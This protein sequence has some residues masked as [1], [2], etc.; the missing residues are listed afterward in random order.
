MRRVL[1]TLFIAGMLN[2][3]I[4][5]AADI[6]LL[7]TSDQRELDRETLRI[8]A[9]ADLQDGVRKLEAMF[10]ADPMAINAEAGKAIGQDSAAIAYMALQW[11]VDSDPDR[12]KLMW[13]GD[14]PHRWFGMDIPWASY[15]FQNQDDIYRQVAIDPHA[16]YEISGRRAGNPPVQARFGLFK[17][18]IDE[19]PVG[20]Q[21]EDIVAE[22]DGSFTITIDSDPANGRANHIQSTPDTK[23]L[24]VR[25]VLSD[26][27]TQTPPTFSIRRLGGPALGQPLDDA[28]IVTRAT[29][30]ASTMVRAW[31]G[32]YSPRIYKQPPNTIAPPFGR[33][34]GWGYL[35]MGRFALGPDEA[36]VVTLDPA[37]AAYVGF[38]LGDA[39]AIPL[40]FVHHTSSLA[41][42]QTKLNPDGT[43]TYVIAARDPGVFNWLDAEGLSAGTLAI[44]WQKLT[45]TDGI[46]GAVRSVRLVKRAD[47]QA[48]RGMVMVMPAERKA[49]IAAREASW[50]RRL[51]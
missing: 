10:R 25:D 20:L 23:L 34:G 4:A 33:V 21:G 37:T 19:I 51:H 50:N 1:L 43:I 24:V 40:E 30:L 46:A 39:W 7:G 31:L 35:T 3:S 47:L 26:W 32:T 42:G 14:A 15:G 28:A 27:A 11:A 6:P 44:R 36:L 9:R 16:R 38:E 41:N 48:T 18:A 8:L 12:P 45:S 22:P 5:D 49:Q 2:A 13:M 17:S 29:D